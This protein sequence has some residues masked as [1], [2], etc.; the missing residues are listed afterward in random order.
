VGKK[1]LFDCAKGVGA[2]E[3]PVVCWGG[4]MGERFVGSQGSGLDV[5]S[6]YGSR[7]LVA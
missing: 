6:V 3:F 1:E 2:F 7:R 4:L 5:E